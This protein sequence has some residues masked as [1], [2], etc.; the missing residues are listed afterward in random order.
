MQTTASFIDIIIIVAL[1]LTA[2]IIGLIAG[3]NVKS[4]KD[5]AV[6]NKNYNTTILTISLIATMVG[7]SPIIGNTAEI[8][9]QGIIHFLAYSGLIIAILLLIKFIIPNF[10]ERFH[11]MISAGDMIKYFYGHNAAIFSSI[12]AYIYST[13]IIALQIIALGSV[14][15]NFLG[16]DFQLGAIIAGSILVIYSASGG[17]RAVTMTDVLQLAILFA[18]IPMI[19]NIPLFKIGGVIE[20]IKQTPSEKFLVF[21]HPEKWSYLLLFFFLTMPFVRLQPEFI[22]RCLMTKNKKTL[23]NVNYIYI[24][25]WLVLTAMLVLT[26][27]SANISL[28]NIHPTEV[29]PAIINEYFPIGLKGFAVAGIIAAIMS[30]ADSCL[31]TSTILLTHNVCFK[32]KNKLKWMK[33]NTILTGIIAIFIGMQRPNIVSLWIVAQSFLLCT[34]CVPV[35]AGLIRLKVCKHSYISSILFGSISFLLA[36]FLIESDNTYIAGF[37]SLISSVLG[38]LIAHIIKNKKL[39]FI[40]KE[41]EKDDDEYIPHPKHNFRSSLKQ[42]LSKLSEVEPN[43]IA[44]GIFSGINYMFPIFLWSDIDSRDDT[45]ILRFIAAVMSIILLTKPVMPP[46]LKKHF[47]SY[48][49]ITLMFCLP[50]LTTVFMLSHY[51]QTISVV[52]LA[53]A[54]FL[55]STLVNWLNFILIAITGVMLGII[56]NSV[57]V[58][59]YVFDLSH[60]YIY[61]IFYTTIYSSIIGVVFTRNREVKTEAKVEI[62]KNVSGA[63][64][65]EVRS[66]LTILTY[67][68]YMIKNT[69]NM[70]IEFKEEAI[71]L[72][73]NVPTRINEIIDGFRNEFHCHENVEQIDLSQL[74]KD[75]LNDYC[76]N[77]QSKKQIETTIGDN[78]NIHAN[79]FLIYTVLKNIIK[80][81]IHAI[82]FKKNGKVKVTAKRNSKALTIIIKDNGKGI[83]QDDINKVFDK[84]YTTKKDGGI[85]L[86][87]SMC[88]TIIEQYDGTIKCESDINKIT[89]FTITLPVE[90]SLKK[91]N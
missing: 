77:E 67:L 12:T 78:C 73:K 33:I 2:L 58:T 76:F 6:A 45:I 71:T 47:Q 26:A 89:K 50:F 14:A 30:T 54:I 10:D 38:F 46:L 69:K 43:Y 57:V 74:I 11:E 19:M 23:V 4:V 51:N 25:C 62:M 44:F 8:Y 81:A 85:G 28:P 29:L 13:V 1:L 53:L 20:L 59:G 66:P 37:I 56:Y 16:L 52:N 21:D 5:Y 55:L 60:E 22:Q 68:E 65:H 90:Y 40:A 15:T 87:L 49:N 7:G 24:W 18:T 84:F 61:T 41:H 63:I 79:K 32:L 3:R 91:N 34:V 72:L 35:F 75:V 82:A 83:P 88:K 86:G 70:T 31:N 9:S 48:W 42:L 39:I 36:Y 27:F 80:N 17:I 64:I